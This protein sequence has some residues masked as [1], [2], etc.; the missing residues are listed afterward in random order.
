[1]FS[2]QLDATTHSP[3]TEEMNQQHSASPLHKQEEEAG[4]KV[5]HEI[6]G[7]LLSVVILSLHCAMDRLSHRSG[8]HLT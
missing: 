5:S 4:V 2:G 6:G 3:A 7:A 1:M 8:I